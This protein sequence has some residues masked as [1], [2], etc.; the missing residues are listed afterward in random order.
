MNATKIHQCDE[1]HCKVGWDVGT[2]TDCDHC[3]LICYK[4][5]HKLDYEHCE[6]CGSLFCPKCYYGKCQ[7]CKTPLFL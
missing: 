7:F 1:C 4:C 6:E 2:F 3:V 5:Y